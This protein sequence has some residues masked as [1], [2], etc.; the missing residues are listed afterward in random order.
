MTEDTLTSAERGVAANA[1]TIAN[2]LTLLD[3]AYGH[4]HLFSWFRHPKPTIRRLR[5]LA[6]TP[7]ISSRSYGVITRGFEEIERYLGN[8]HSVINETRRTAPSNID[9]N[10]DS[11]TITIADLESAAIGLV[12]RIRRL[13]NEVKV[14]FDVIADENLQTRVNPSLELIFGLLSPESD[15]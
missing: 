7:K 14:C 11:S 2:M 13:H 3:A 12:E 6:A 4:R 1:A 10:I 15:Q 8:I 5:R 9:A